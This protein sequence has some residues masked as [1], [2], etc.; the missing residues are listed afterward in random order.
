MTY[1]RTTDR[2]PQNYEL[3]LSISVGAFVVNGLHPISVRQVENL[4]FCNVACLHYT[5]LLH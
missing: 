1:S 2:Q 5:T 3:S 4:S